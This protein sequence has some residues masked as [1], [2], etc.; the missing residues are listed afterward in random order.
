MIP[1]ENKALGELG[2][3]IVALGE[4]TLFENNSKGELEKFE[5]L[6]HDAQKKKLDKISAQNHSKILKK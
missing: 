5:Q 3:A 6:L 1:S 2:H 4:S